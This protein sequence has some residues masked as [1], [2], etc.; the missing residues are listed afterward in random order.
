M[1]LAQKLVVGG[2]GRRGRIGEVGP[3]PSGGWQLPSGYFETAVMP[4]RV[5]YPR[6]N[7]ETQTFARHRH[8][9]PGLQYRIPISIQGGAYPFRFEVV[10]GPSGMVVGETVGATDYGVVTWTPSAAGG[11]YN[12]VIRVTDQDLLL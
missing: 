4:L 7:T 6:P 9:Y 5:V 1:K 3:P 10:E 11:P 8:A 12:V 2:R